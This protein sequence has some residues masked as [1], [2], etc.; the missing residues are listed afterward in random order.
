MLNQASEGFGTIEQINEKSR[1][2]ADKSGELRVESEEMQAATAQNTESSLPQAQDAMPQGQ[3]IIPAQGTQ[4]QNETAKSA[5]DYLLENIPGQNN[6]ASEA[7]TESTA[8]DDNPKAHTAEETAK[9]EEYKAAVDENLVSFIENV[10]D[11]PNE[12]KGQYPLKPVSDRAAADIKTKTGVD[13]TGNKTVIEA[14]I[15]KHI[16]NRHGENGA[17]NTSMKD[18]NDIARIQ[19][20]LDNYDDVSPSG[21]TAAYVTNKANGKHGQAKAV[22][23]SKAVDGTYYI[24]EAVPDTAKKTVYVVTAYMSNEKATGLSSVN[25]EALRQT[26]E[27]A[28]THPVANGSTGTVLNMKKNSPQVTSETPQRANA[29]ATNVPES[30]ENVKSEN[31]AAEAAKTQE[32]ETHRQTRKTRIWGRMAR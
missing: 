2:A 4:I 32:G 17:A 26:S 23:F 20:V 16:L 7:E 27:T 28:A 25:A 9:I 30:G 6:N 22:V 29:S 11:N 12:T 1:N 21:T 24:V 19:Y 15:I 31:N 13:V 14:R 10:R 8:V 3:T 18:I 5:E